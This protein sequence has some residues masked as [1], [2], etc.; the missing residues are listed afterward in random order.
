[1]RREH[2]TDPRNAHELERDAVRSEIHKPQ[3]RVPD[4]ILHCEPLA[5]L[6]R[7][8]YE[9][10]LSEPD[11][12]FDPN[13]DDS[14]AAPLLE[15]L[16]RYAFR[17]FFRGAI[18]NS[19]NFLPEETTKFLKAEQ[20]QKE[21]D[22]L[23]E[24][25]FAEKIDEKRYKLIE[26]ASSFGPTLEWYV[27]RQ[28]KNQLGIQA[29][30]GVHFRATGVG[31]DLDILASTENK[32]IV[33]ELKSSPPKHLYDDEVNAFF[34]RILTL[35]PHISIFAVDTALRLYDK[36]IPML[37]QGLS[38]RDPSKTPPQST[39]IEREL[40]AVTPHIFA[41]NSKPT[42]IGNISRTIAEGLKNLSPDPW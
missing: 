33:I 32:L 38:R 31:G 13:M 8:G 10:T 26:H 5:M 18:Q 3:N 42:L 14:R 37:E 20:A 12:P 4:E 9:P 28:L 16:E 40:F 39:C 35:K 30:A 41:V 36:V 15:H 25:G 27:A 11:V 24:I 17:L 7:R 34:E 2:P 1:M 23:V 22:R 29:V 21:A 19:H 6:L